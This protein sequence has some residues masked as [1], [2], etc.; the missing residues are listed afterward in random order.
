M[1]TESILTHLDRATRGPSP[2]HGNFKVLLAACLVL[3]A[4]AISVVDLDRFPEWDEAVFLSQSGDVLEEDGE[5]VSLVASRELGTPTLLS[6]IRMAVD[7]LANTK[8]VWMA[9]SVIALAVAANLISVHLRLSAATFI[10]IY[11]THWLGLL[12][13]TSFYGFFLASTAALMSV[14]CY[15]SLRADSGRQVHW[16][17]ALGLALA[18]SFWF[19]QIESFLVVAALILHAMTRSPRLMLAERGRGFVA[20]AV[21]FLVTF[22]IPW[23]VDSTIR[24]G[25]VAQRINQGS[26]QGFG[27]GLSNQLPEYLDVFTGKASHYGIYGPA[28]TWA[29]IAIL[30]ITVIALILAGFGYAQAR[31]DS[32]KSHGR[33]REVS[34]LLLVGL[35]LLG[36][37][38]FYIHDVSERYLLMGSIFVTGV[39]LEGLSRWRARSRM[40]GAA[41]ALLATMSIVWIVSNAVI[42]RTYDA[43]RSEAG[44]AVYVYGGMLR[45]LADGGDCAG[46]SRYG[47]PRVAFASGCR[48][49]SAATAADASETLHKLSSEDRLIFVWWPAGYVDEVILPDRS[50]QNLFAGHE[51]EGNEPM[52]LWSAR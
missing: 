7:G 17:V 35:T 39:V 40:G 41:L 2:S 51:R 31:A 38:A 24:F 18:L 23:S 14:A 20:S 28:P 19:R 11:G 45:E 32:P 22:A 30:L 12:F 3:L 1:W 34:C 6:I 25:S 4:I 29:R 27:R 21:V 49:W 52:I 15:L 36:F 16:G 13:I 26:R 47:A 42:A 37:F 9:V 43:G 5:P 33:F 44:T 50:W 46:V 10:I 8:I 48:V